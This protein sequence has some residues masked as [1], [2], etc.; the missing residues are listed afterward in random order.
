MADGRDGRPLEGR[1]RFRVYNL[2]DSEQL[3]VDIN[4]SPIPDAAII[5]RRKTNIHVAAERR[6]PGMHIPPHIAYEVD[7]AR[8]PPFKGDNELG[9]VF[10]KP[11]T[12]IEGVIMVEAL[13]IDVGWMGH[14]QSVGYEVR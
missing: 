12:S 13:E 9:F 8:C 1:L 2:H 6:Y 5:E 7:L 4:N 11:D 14:P 3:T 10:S